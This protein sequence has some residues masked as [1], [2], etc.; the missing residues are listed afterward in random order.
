MDGTCAI[1]SSGVAEPVMKTEERRKERKRER[2]K[3]ERG[4]AGGDRSDGGPPRVPL[5]PL[6]GL[7]SP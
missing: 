3:R 4:R 2:G 6:L 1:A 7:I 5:A